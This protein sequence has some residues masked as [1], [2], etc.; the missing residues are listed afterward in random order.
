LARHGAVVL[1]GYTSENI[2]I[3]PIEL[4]LTETRIL[5]SVAASRDDLV[6]ALKLAARGSLKSTIDTR[7][8]LGEVGTAFERLRQRSVLGRNVLTWGT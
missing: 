1:I 6:T 5:S 8:P 7:Y 4:I 2:D 3:H